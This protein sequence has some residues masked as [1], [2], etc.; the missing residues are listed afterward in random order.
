LGIGLLAKRIEI[1]R[2]TMPSATSIGFLVNPVNPNI[3]ANTSEARSAAATFGQKL[4]LAKV[5]T[6]RDIEDAVAMFAEAR[7]NALFVDDDSFFNSRTV[8][9]TALAA[10]HAL[11]AMYPLPEYVAA[12]GLMSYG[13]NLSASYRQAGAYAGHILKGER[14]ADLPVCCRPSSILS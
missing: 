5:A 13:S 12:G 2:S 10:R 14:P 4:V 8:Q 6:D 11:P 7:V 1:L 9:L 3:D